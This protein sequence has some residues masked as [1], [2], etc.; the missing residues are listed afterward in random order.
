LPA[1]EYRSF[2]PE[3]GAGMGCHEHDHSSSCAA[4]GSYR[5][6]TDG[7]YDRLSNFQQ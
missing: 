7:V 3:P 1:S 4:S 5:S 2:L 6:I